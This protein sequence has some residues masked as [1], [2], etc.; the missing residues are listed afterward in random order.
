MQDVAIV[1]AGELGGALAHVLARRDVVGSIRLIDG[2]G[3]VAAG[4]ALDIMQASPVN[5]F[6][7]KVSGTNDVSSAAGA[8]VVVIADRLGKGEWKGDDAVLLLKQISEFARQAIVV[9]SGASQREIVERGVREHR[10][11]AQ[12]LLGTPPEAFAA[13]LRAL[14]ALETNG[15]VR[16]VALTVL[17]KPPQHT[18]IPWHSVTVAGF[19]ATEVLSEP[20]RRKIE[21][22]LAHLWPPGPY[23]LATAAAEAVVSIVTESRRTFSAFVSPSVDSVGGGGRAVAW[24]V[25][26]G[27]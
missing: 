3:S 7:T 4:K 21:T 5:Q 25:K 2:A 22:R 17:G 12:R 23:A 18:V 13:T 11:A 16:D 26:L 20:V 14:I 15:S 24:P 8:A 27:P 9:C 19:A 6:A 10:Y 1:G